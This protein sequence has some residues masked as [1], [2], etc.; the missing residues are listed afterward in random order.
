[1]ANEPVSARTRIPATLRVM[2]LLQHWKLATTLLVIAGLLAIYHFS[3]Q[4]SWSD[5]TV[6][7]VVERASA[8]ASSQYRLP[9]VV[10]H[11]RLADGTVVA[12]AVPHSTVVRLGQAVEL[13]VLRRMLTDAPAFEFSRYVDGTGNAMAAPAFREAR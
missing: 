11:V 12:A 1:M 6:V 5:T 7:G 2:L 9:V 4:L 13:R 8:E 3:G 10:L